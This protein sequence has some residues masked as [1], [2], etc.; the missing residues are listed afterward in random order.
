MRR[1]NAEY[2]FSLYKEYHVPQ[3]VVEHMVK[4]AEFSEKLCNKFIKKGLKINK[5]LVIQAALLHDLVRISDFRTIN[6]RKLKQ[7]INSK[8]L[9]KW[10]E[11]RKKHQKDGHAQAAYGIL[12]NLGHK[13][14]AKLVL[15]HALRRIG[16][17]KTW[18][19]KILYYADK[20][21]EGGRVVRLKTRL[22][23]IQKRSAKHIE[24]EQEIFKLE[25][26]IK[27]ALL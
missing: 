26:E 22:K 16:E 19:E 23:N 24:M 5:N 25:R 9:E 18:E 8:D 15:N 10:I 1:V 4:V 14:I 20:R 7:K 13:H 2:I 3:K 6:L 21:V 11:L 12:S 27:K 17:L